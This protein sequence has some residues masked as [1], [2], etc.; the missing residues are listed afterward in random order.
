MELA[1][2]DDIKNQQQESTKPEKP[3]ETIEMNKNQNLHRARRSIQLFSSASGF[4]AV[5]FGGRHIKTFDGSVYH[6]PGEKKYFNI[7]KA[8]V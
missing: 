5:V 2:T 1:S 7:H 6:F 4:T 3:T 8:E